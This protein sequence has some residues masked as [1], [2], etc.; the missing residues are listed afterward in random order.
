MNNK[1]KAKLILKEIEKYLSFEKMQRDFATK[2]ILK[3]LEEIQ[4]NEE[5]VK[6]E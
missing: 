4:K 6:E 1:D 5:Q 3:A 2:G